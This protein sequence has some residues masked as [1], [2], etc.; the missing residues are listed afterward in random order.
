M[1]AWATKYTVY[2]INYSAY[3]INV[4]TFAFKTSIAQ[5]K[6]EQ[7]IIILNIKFK[8]KNFNFNF[9]LFRTRLNNKFKTPGQFKDFERN[10]KLYIY[11]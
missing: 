10:K 5:Y 9:S 1:H 3:K 2:N 7:Q 4:L 6:Y 11:L 8:C